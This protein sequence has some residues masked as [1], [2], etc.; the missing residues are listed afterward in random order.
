[1]KDCNH[2]ISRDIVNH[3]IEHG[4]GTIKIEALSGIRH[5]TTRTSRGAKAR[6][7]NRMKNTWS[8]YQLTLFI[9]YKAARAGIRVEKVDP[10][11][12]SKECP[13]CTHRNTAQDRTYVCVECG[14]HGHRD[15]VGAINIS[16]RTG[17]VG[18]RQGATRATRSARR[19]AA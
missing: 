9:T 1:M 19:R 14:W 15:A 8:F 18:D 5:G 10:A 13:A 16:R 7:N 11:Y 6:K 4:V 2:K 17:L 3:A 12:T